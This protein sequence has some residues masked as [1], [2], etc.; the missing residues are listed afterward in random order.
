MN[1]DTK[2]LIKQVEKLGHRVQVK[3]TGVVQVFCPDGTIV[4]FH[5]TESDHRALKNTTAR[6]RRAGVQL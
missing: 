2:K 1:K 3:K 5:S 6:L 4:T